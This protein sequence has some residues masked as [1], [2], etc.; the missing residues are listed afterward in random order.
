M[1]VEHCQ[2]KTPLGPEY[3]WAVPPALSRTEPTSFLEEGLK[4]FQGT[5]HIN[6]IKL[7]CKVNGRT[8][9]THS[10]RL[11]Q[12]QMQNQRG[13][14]DQ[15]LDQE[16]HRPFLFLNIDGKILNSIRKLNLAMH[17]EALKKNT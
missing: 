11:I 7:F 16:N 1:L 10:I 9:P 3:A 5:G 6:I 13:K 15:E 14:K 12:L 8:F 4:I 2:W 17:F